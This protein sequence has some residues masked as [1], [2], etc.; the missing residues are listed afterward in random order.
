MNR[1]TLSFG[2]TLARKVPG[3]LARDRIR[4]LALQDRIVG[5]IDLAV[6][7]SEHPQ[8]RDV[9]A[10][11]DLDGLDPA[12]VLDALT[13]AAERVRIVHG[14]PASD[15]L[16]IAADQRAE[17]ERLV[18]MIRSLGWWERVCGALQWVGSGAEF[19][20]SRETCIRRVVEALGAQRGRAEIREDAA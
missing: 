4:A 19:K 16:P 3:D 18:D 13:I 8:R 14:L 1:R 6:V 12:L 7:V 10:A 11:F 2:S 5:M 20:Y 15:A 17:A 9:E